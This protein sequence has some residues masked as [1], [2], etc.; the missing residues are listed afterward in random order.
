VIRDQHVTIESRSSAC[1]T[2]V[3]ITPLPIVVAIVCIVAELNETRAR[4]P[5]RRNL[6][7]DR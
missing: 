7:S 6:A 4:I 1:S 3:I 2:P 5:A